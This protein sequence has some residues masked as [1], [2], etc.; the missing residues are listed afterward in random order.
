MVKLKISQE[1]I[2]NWLKEGTN[3]H[4]DPKIGSHKVSQEP[5]TIVFFL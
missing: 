4:L 2:L 3:N 5:S 1:T